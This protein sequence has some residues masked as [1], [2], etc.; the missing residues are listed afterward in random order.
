M[1]SAFL[2]LLFVIA[3]PMAVFALAAALMMHMTGRDQ[4]PQ[5]SMPESAP[6]NLRLNGYNTAAASTYWQWLG[7][8]GRLAE[9]RF[10]EADMIFPFV[11]GGAMLVSILLAWTALGRPFD[12][13]LLIAPVV[14]TVIADW[15]ENLVHWRQLRNFLQSEPI[16]TMWIQIGSIATSTK[17]VFLWMSFLLIVGFGIWMFIH[18]LMAS[19]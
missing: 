6:L 18:E 9:R 15:I 8:D 1:G 7:T 4:F 12:P 11:Y 19:K 17:L 14:V 3:M 13:T 16:Q 5:S 2:K 10:L